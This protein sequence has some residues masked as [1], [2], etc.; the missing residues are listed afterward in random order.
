MFEQKLSEPKTETIKA[1]DTPEKIATIKNHAEIMIDRIHFEKPSAL[2]FLD[3]AARPISWILVEAWKKRYPKEKL[4][5][6]KYIDI[7]PVKRRLAKEAPADGRN[8]LFDPNQG[9]DN[10]FDKNEWHER[11]INSEKTKKIWQ[12]LEVDDVLKKM[13]PDLNGKNGT[14]L[15]I[16]D[17][18]GSGRTA[19]LAQD[20]LKFHFPDIR[21]ETDTFFNEIDVMN[22]NKK[23]FMGTALP[24]NT[25]KEY[26]LM[27]GD[28]ADEDNRILAKTEKDIEKRKK[29]L[30]LKQEIKELFIDFK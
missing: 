28:E 30:A 21:F 16:D 25:E 6:I 10:Y 23:N 26:T 7:G 18:P 24:W 8:N 27:A 13:S 15:I 12:K 11:T 9:L 3:R 29:G 4:P 14:V 20:F 1:F 5:P 22:F 19:Q 2:V 17:Y